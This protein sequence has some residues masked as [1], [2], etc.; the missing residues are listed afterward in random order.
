MNATEYRASIKKLGMSQRRAARFFEAG[1][2]T[3]VRWAKDGPP[4]AIGMMLTLMLA[5]H[6]KPSWV[7]Y[8]LGRK[9]SA[10]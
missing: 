3:A 4:P 5:L 8:W 2:A 6:V 1:P 7:D 10:E 9:N